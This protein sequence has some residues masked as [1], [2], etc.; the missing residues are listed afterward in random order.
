MK[1][2][3]IIEDDENHT[4]LYDEDGRTTWYGMKL[5]SLLA[6]VTEWWKKEESRDV[7]VNRPKEH[8]E[9]KVKLDWYHYSDEEFDKML[10]KHL[11]DV[12]KKLIYEGKIYIRISGG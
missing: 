5:D 1:S 6:L 12:M 11:P 10:S 9:K 4:R 2:L 3:L 7:M 8:P